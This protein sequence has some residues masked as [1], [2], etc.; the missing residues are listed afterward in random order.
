V[1]PNRVAAIVWIIAGAI[2]ALAGVLLSGFT[3]VNTTEMALALVASLAAA[4]LAGFESV[5]VAVGA[6]A[7]VGAVTSAAASI[8]ELAR[9]S[10][11]V[12]SAGFG[13]VVLVVLIVRPRQLTAALER[14]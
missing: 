2:A 8:P 7:G 3:V 1:R 9:I 12:E 11:F 13:A 4:L 5:P 14:A 10:G 6:S